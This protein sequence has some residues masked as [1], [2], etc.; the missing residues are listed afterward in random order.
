[1]AASYPK[2]TFL[3]TGSAVPSKY[4]NVTSILVESRPDNYVML[5]C[6]D[7]TLLQLIRRFGVKKA[8]GILRNL[9]AI[10]ISHLHADHHLGFIGLIN[11]R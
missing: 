3:G 5:D 7:G 2:V 10:Y 1:M 4:R 9:K 8:Q 6:G 11:Y